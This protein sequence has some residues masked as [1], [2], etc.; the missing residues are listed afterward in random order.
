MLVFAVTAA[1]PRESSWSIYCSGDDDNET[2]IICLGDEF[3]VTWIEDQDNV[4]FY[5][6]LKQN[7]G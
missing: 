5:F 6:Y 2:S 7:I 3:S 1:G 4:T